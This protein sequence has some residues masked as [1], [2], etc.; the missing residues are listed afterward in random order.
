[1]VNSVVSRQELNLISLGCPLPCRRK[2]RTPIIGD[3]TSTTLWCQNPCKRIGVYWDR[4]SRAGGALGFDPKGENNANGTPYSSSCRLG[5]QLY[6]TSE[7]EGNWKLDRTPR[8]YACYREKRSTATFSSAYTFLS[9]DKKSTA[10]YPNSWPIDS[11]ISM[12]PENCILI[13]T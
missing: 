3:P 13:K 1:M 9:V 7:K 4:R 11:I 10:H 5:S 12:S 6:L 8:T 2:S